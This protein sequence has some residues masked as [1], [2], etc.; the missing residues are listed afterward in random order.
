M[1]RTGKLGA[2]L[3]SLILLFAGCGGS[4]G[5]TERKYAVDVIVKKADADFW[6]VVQMGTEAAGR[7]FGI[8]VNFTGPADEKDIDGQI[9]MVDTAITRKVDA[10]VL[11]ASDYTQLADAV[12]RTVEANIPVIIIDSDVQSDRTSCFIGTDNVDAGRKLGETLV[13][14]VGD[15]CKIAVMGFIKGAATSDQREEGLMKVVAEHP[16]INVLSMMYCKSDEDIAKAQTMDI[17]SI[18]PDID[19]IVCLNAYGTEGT[20]L[21]IDELELSGKVK[22]IGFD[23]TPEEIRY[24]E[25]GV[26]QALVVQ[27]PYSMGYLGVKHA[28]D[29]I[30]GKTVPKSVDTGASVV[31]RENMYQPENQKLLFPFTS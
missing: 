19:A 22:I 11:A 1:G 29:A 7:E 30:Q 15:N 4:L 6:K 5:G 17:I 31:D 18:N 28:L 25:K 3:L 26:I 2:A 23:S 8:T 27:N 21:A 10:I 24:L 16:G 9:K 20:A 13:D 12:D 14:K